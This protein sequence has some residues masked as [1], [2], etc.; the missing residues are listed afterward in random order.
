MLA[1]YLKKSK[2]RVL[3]LKKL[4]KSNKNPDEQFVYNLRALLGFKIKNI[5]LY[6]KAFTHRS[7]NLK[8]KEGFFFNY[9][10]LEF[11][12]DSVLGTI[13]SNYLYSRYHNY[14]EGD[15]TKL[16]S[17]II[18]RYSLNKIGFS[19]KLHKL[20]KASFRVN[21][22]SD[23]IHGNLLEALVGAIYVDKG[24]KICENFVIKKIIVRINFSNINKSIIS[25][26]AALI[27]WGQKEKKK[28]KFKTKINTELNNKNYFYSTL[29]IDQIK[30]AYA[31]DESKKKAEEKVSKISYR[32]LEIN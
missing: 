15:L 25:Y 11:L 20:V 2:L 10:R 28:V 30:I 16:R 29:F 32:I 7:T 21:E 4:F 18:N 27:E 9:E 1:F 22:P 24:Y 31:I 6:K 23:D 17:K 3:G 13:I 8:D 26:K 19:L 12:G 5:L 14:N